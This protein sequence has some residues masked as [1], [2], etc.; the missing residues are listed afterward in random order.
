M[1]LKKIVVII[2]IIFMFLILLFNTTS[3]A[4]VSTGLYDPE[5]LNIGNNERAFQLG[6]TIV[7]VLKTVGTVIAVVGIM[8]LG[9]KYMLGS[10]E[11]K[12]DYKK[13]MIPYVVGCIMIFAIGQIVSII[14]NLVAQV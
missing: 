9:I 6:G 4:Y 11:Q 2:S 7:T 1:K 3:M 8:I 10:V 14:Y 12:A 13:T 5:N